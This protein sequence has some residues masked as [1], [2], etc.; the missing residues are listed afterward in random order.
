MGVDYGFVRLMCARRSSFR[1]H[2]G[3]LEVNKIHPAGPQKDFV[4]NISLVVKG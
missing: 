3:L 2:R 4:N 1:I